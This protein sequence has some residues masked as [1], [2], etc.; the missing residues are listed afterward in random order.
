MA[1]QV[2]PL[3]LGLCC[4]NDSI[5]QAARSVR[6]RFLAFG[7]KSFVDELNLAK[8]VRFRSILG[9]I[10]GMDDALASAVPQGNETHL[11]S[12]VGGTLT[13]RQDPRPVG[14]W[15]FSIPSNTGII[16]LSN[17]AI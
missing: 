8:C 13:D 9:M 3:T 12:E 15:G 14:L 6:Y 16:R 7:S 2:E 1:F 17:S 11:Q 4:K 5:D 10:Q